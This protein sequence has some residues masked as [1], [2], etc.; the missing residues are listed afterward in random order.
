LRAGDAAA[1]VVAC[2]R[3]LADFP[4]DGNLLCLA[5]R[6]N[7]VLRRIEHARQLVESALAHYPDFPVAHDV[8]GD[9]LL[10]EGDPTAALSAYERAL[11]LDPGLPQVPVKRDRARELAAAIPLRARRERRERRARFAEDMLEAE[12]HERNGAKDKAEAIYR[13][14]LRTDP[15]HVEAA[16]ALAGIAVEHERYREAEVFLKKAVELAP[17]YTRAWVD[18]ANVQRHLDKHEEALASARRVVEQSPGKA[19][20]HMLLG[21]VL[22][23]AGEHEAAIQAFEQVLAMEPDRGGALLTLAHH[24]KTIGRQQE[25]IDRYRECLAMHPENGEAWWSLA[26][27]K[28]FHF[29][30]DE[31]DR[32]QQQVQHPDLPDDAR[33]QIHNALG[34]AFESRRDYARAFEHFA[35]CNRIRRTMEKYD[36]VD[37]E[38]THDRVIELLDEK[39]LAQ[40]AGVDV[41]PIP[42]FVVGLPRSGSTLIEQILAS[43]SQV[44]GTHELSDLSKV[45]RGLRRSAPG[46]PRYPASVAELGASDWSRLGR[47]YLER[48]AQYR[49]AGAP[50]FIDK[51]PNNFV[52][53]GLIRLAL[54][55]ARIVNA[56]RHPLDSCL[57]SFKQLFASGQPFTY[58][59]VELGEY[60]LEYRRVMD[61]WHRVLSGFVLDVHYEQVVGDLEGQVRRLLDFCGL[62]FEEA[63]LRFHETERAVKTASSEQVRQPIYTSSV[64][65]WRRY[66]AEL[67]ALIEVLAPLLRRLPPADRPAGLGPD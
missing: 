33:L 43:H 62:P 49:G 58:D 13:H 22:G 4:A 10:V 60:Y 23:S 42:I 21:T 3:A 1:A 61:H 41:S 66:E 32:M 47:D 50:F 59:L 45:V 55:N 29:R 6:A 67:G 36:P 2:D 65:L 14:I 53:A 56:M 20:A 63:C 52:F 44:E 11:E 30:D 48:T 40:P 16:R 19:E 51:N 54:P 5:G 57:G 38:T 8:L 12:Q 7:I 46:D 26:N 37:T 18:L 25:A 28:T 15:E 24:L 39:F 9:L 64:N 31:I 17:D 34:F 27:L 35:A